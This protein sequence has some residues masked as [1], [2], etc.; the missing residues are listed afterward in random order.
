MVAPKRLGVLA[1][2]YQVICMNYSTEW[3]IYNCLGCW[4]W[5]NTVLPVA[6]KGVLA[7]YILQNQGREDDNY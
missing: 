4:S 2:D 6:D 5:S 3:R 7:L 1:S